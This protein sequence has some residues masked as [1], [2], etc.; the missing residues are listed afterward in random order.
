MSYTALYGKRDDGDGE[1][2]LIVC[3][4]YSLDDLSPQKYM[5]VLQKKLLEYSTES[6]IISDETSDFPEIYSQS[7]EVE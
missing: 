2:L 6:F 4:N 1:L 5:K 7:N 3:N